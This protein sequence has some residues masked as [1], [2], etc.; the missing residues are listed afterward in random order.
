MAYGIGIDTG[1]TYTDAVVYDFDA[2]KVVAKGKSPT[3]HHELSLGIGRALDMLPTDMLRCAAI[4]SLSTT[5]ATN[6]CVEGKGG[7]ARLVMLGTEMST[8]TRVGADKKYGLKYEDV[9]C[10]DA[11]AAYDGSTAEQPDWEKIISENEAF[12][13][14]ADALCVAGLNS[15]R[16]G[17]VNELA[18]RDAL[19]ARFNVPFMMASELAVDLNIMERG[20]T[21]LL[22]ARLLPVVDEFMRAVTA[23]LKERGLDAEQMIV[24]SDG[25]LMSAAYARSRPVQ[26]IL[27]G[28]AASVVGCRALADNDNC[29]IVDMGGTT[30]DISVVRGGKPDMSGGIS[31][32]GWRTQ[33]K[34]V[35]IDTFAL[36]GDTRICLQDGR[37][38][39]DKR[40]VE[41]ICA[42]AARFP[43]VRAQLENLLPNMRR[44][45]RQLHEFLYLLRMPV[46][47]ENYT[48]SERRLLNDL[49][50]GPQ[51][52]GGG[53]LEYYGSAG[54]RLERE[55]YVMRCGFTPTDVMHLTGAY[56][57]FDSEAARLAARCLL[58]ALYDYDDTPEDMLRLAEAAND[59]VKRRM[60]KNILRVFMESEYPE[61]RHHGIDER[62]GAIIDRRWNS[63][64]DAA[65]NGFFELLP[66]IDAVLVGTG[67]PIHIFLPDVAKA[68][69]AR[70][71]IPEN[72]EVANAIGAVAADISAQAS[73]RI[74]AEYT[75]EGA[76][77]HVL[78]APGV[79]RYEKDM[80]QAIAAAK[81]IAEK[82]ACAEARSRGALGQLTTVVTVDRRRGR[83]RE[84]AAVDLGTEV[85]AHT[86]G[87]LNI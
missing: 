75:Y 8:L 38:F 31:I 47:P 32:G 22:N 15:T 12:F 19:K 18:A 68:L 23:A 26:T 56:T 42:A 25:S 52:I 1:G 51:L 79:R 54:E 69:G 63:R 16:N 77:R 43:S 39:L 84:G 55:G 57:A 71:I 49:Q 59:M 14:D 64:N 36:G 6:A 37:L 53:K 10:V 41:P 4:V 73:V 86:T 50:D 44:H 62:L 60:F 76:L 3:T 85:I 46:H 45:T 58:R 80:E 72:S 67:A 87:R 24:R 5:L 74:T 7:R 2:H 66:R 21:A 20:A 27:S 35:Y 28:P 9:L 29:L 17:A 34:G 40:R 65:G 61:I 78:T 11:K 48:D 30:T 81:D 82:L 33:I 70:C 83:D 13:A